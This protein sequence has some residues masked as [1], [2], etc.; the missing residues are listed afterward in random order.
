MNE[1]AGILS[2]VRAM[3]ASDLFLAPG[4]PPMV[5]LN[6]QVS[7]LPGFN[8]L[9]E[10][11]CKALIY[12]G[13]FENGRQ[14][15][16]QEMELDYSFAVQGVARF[17]V[18][19]LQ[20]RG[21]VSAVY[22]VIPDAIPTPQELGLSPA[23]IALADLPRGLVLVTGATGSGKSTTLAALIETI[24]QRHSKNIITIEDPIEFV[25]ERK[26]SLILQ[27]EV[28][29]HTKSFKEALRRALRQAP[30]VILVGELRDQETIQLA[31]TAAETGHLCFATLHTQDCA[32]SIDRI[33]DVFPPEQQQ[34]VRTQLSMTLKA[35]LSQMLLQRKDA[36]GRV[37]VRE[38][39]TSSI[40]IASL[41]RENKGHMIYSVMETGQE[42]G[43]QTMEQH[44]A[45]LIQ[46]GYIGPDE[47]LSKAGAP[48]IVKQLLKMTDAP[49]T[50][51]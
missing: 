50:D 38:F 34:Q 14:R 29:Q 20:Q 23:M 11:T 21:G 28:G 47:A 35:V 9:S 7:P 36:P 12:S 37:A 46:R 27:R 10:G 41:I 4:T 13:I 25:Y 49:D 45:F 31:L 24:N 8:A 44:L 40:A 2:K 42:T 3:G 26:K 19:V 5:K 16:E 33:I 30:D 51:K 15:F 17:R 18:N 22:R 32:T 48:H 43:M 6:G 39:M 1:L